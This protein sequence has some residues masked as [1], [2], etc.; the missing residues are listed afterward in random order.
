MEIA[1]VVPRILLRIL[2]SFGCR[3]K[4]RIKIILPY[5]LPCYVY[6]AVVYVMEGEV[7]IFGNY[8]IKGIENTDRKY[9]LTCL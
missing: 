4:K 3:L 2:M 6:L 1:E 8:F 9:P 7:N 5:N